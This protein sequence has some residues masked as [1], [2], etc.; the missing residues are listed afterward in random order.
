MDTV[1]PSENVAKQR[2]GGFERLTRES[3]GNPMQYRILGRTGVKVSRLCLGTMMFGG[4]TDK[5]ESKRIIDHALDNGVNF[6]DTADMYCGGVSEEIVGKAIGK[7]RDKCVLASKVGLPIPGQPDT[8][9]LSRRYIMNAVDAS[10]SR[11]GLDHIDIYY[12]HRMDPDTEF[13]EI[14][15]AFGDLIRAG[16]IRYWALSNVKA[17]HISHYVDLC[18]INSIPQPVALQPYYNLLNR[19][20]EVEHIPAARYFGMGV[21]PYSPIARGVL[22][23][24]YAKGATAPKDSRAGRKDPRILATEMRDESLVIAQKLLAHACDKA[25][26]GVD[27]AVAWVLNNAAVTSCIAGPRT[28]EQWQSYFGAL[29]YDWSAEDEKLVD[30][31]VAPGQRSTPGYFDPKEPPEGRFPRV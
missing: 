11:L 24:K 6:I 15:H 25:A 19:T 29:D 8:G 22:T 27:F 13:E 17:W 7:K 21:V 5:K 4:R 2:A 31:L 26:T 23:G 18:R 16:K 10:L 30:S 28:F 20:P 3:Q 12:L 14:V 1:Y 9:G